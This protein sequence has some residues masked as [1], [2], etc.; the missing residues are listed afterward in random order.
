MPK[1]GAGS[2]GKRP[3]VQRDRV[4]RGDRL[5]AARDAQRMSQIEC[6]MRCNLMVRQVSD[7]E[8]GKVDPSAAALRRI[9]I[10]M[11]L[12]VDWLLGLTDEL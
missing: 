11:E 2:G 3:R 5:R 10:G 12:S 4:F 9:A 6:A 1:R 7:F 8:R